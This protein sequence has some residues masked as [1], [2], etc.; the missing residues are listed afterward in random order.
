[1]QLIEIQLSNFC[2]CNCL[3]TSSKVNDFDRKIKVVAKSIKDDNTSLTAK[4]GDADG[5]TR[6]VYFY[7]A[8]SIED[9]QKFADLQVEQLK[10]SG[11]EGSFEV[12]GGL[13]VNHGDIIEIVNPQIP[14]QS[15]GYICEKI[16]T[17]C[18]MNGLRQNIAIKQKLYN[19]TKNS[20]GKWTQ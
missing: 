19:L 12:F 20:S 16:T 3:S 2:Q 6:T 5:E 17:S 15:G 14:E 9:L 10:Y 8:D 1:M 11:Y 7:N 13:P 18:G 4:A